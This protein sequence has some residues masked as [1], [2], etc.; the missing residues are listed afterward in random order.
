MFLVYILVA[1]AQRTRLPPVRR[2]S[3]R[4]VKGH[5]GPLSSRDRERH[6]TYAPNVADPV[7]HSV[8]QRAG[9]AVTSKRGSDIHAPHAPLVIRFLA[10]EPEESHRSDE[11]AVH[12]RSEDEVVLPRIAQTF[13]GDGKWQ[14]PKFRSG[15][16][17]RMRRFF[18]RRQPE[19]PEL[20]RIV[21]REYAQMVHAGRID[22]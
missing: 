19:P 5:R 8:K 1:D 22:R 13:N 17:K 4:R 9:D 7:Q 3:G 15:L 18:E 21:R 10:L 20:L 11:A 6:L 16:G 14:S 2:E 12:K